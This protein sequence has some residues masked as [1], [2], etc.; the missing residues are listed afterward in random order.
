MKPR[1]YLLMIIF[2]LNIQR[3][4][5]VCQ[6]DSFCFSLTKLRLWEELFVFVPSFINFIFIWPEPNTYWKDLPFLQQFLLYMLHRWTAE[7]SSFGYKFLYL[8]S[9]FTEGSRELHWLPLRCM[10]AA[11]NL[12]RLSLLSIFTTT[13]MA[14]GNALCIVARTFLL[15]IIGICLPTCLWCHS[16]IVHYHTIYEQ[17][18]R[19]L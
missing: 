6:L 18:M 8:F 4:I 7:P 14:S 13:S 16:P 3:G 5:I 9:F 2:L 11:K 1:I 17:K 15:D 19:I 10:H 12:H